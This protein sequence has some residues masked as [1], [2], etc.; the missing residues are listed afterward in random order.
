MQIQTMHKM[1]LLSQRTKAEVEAEDIMIEN[2]IVDHNQ[3]IDLSIKKLENA[4]IVGKKWP[5]KKR[6]LALE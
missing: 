5:Q 3:E 2:S 1:K 6:L 4:S